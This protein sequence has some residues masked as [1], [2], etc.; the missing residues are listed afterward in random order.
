[1]M[2]YLCL[3]ILSTLIITN[4]VLGLFQGRETRGAPDKIR[5]IFWK[6]RNK[7]KNNQMGT[8][9]IISHVNLT[10]IYVYLC[11][12]FSLC[13]LSNMQDLIAFIFH[14]AASF[15]SWLQMTQTKVV[16]ACIENSYLGL[17][18]L[19]SDLNANKR[20]SIASIVI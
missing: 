13:K 2:K 16:H 12:H 9:P 10:P 8:L 17:C 6:L 20:T 3:S 14:H 15:Y 4:S 19:M 11:F 1:M 7:K 18:F 5:S